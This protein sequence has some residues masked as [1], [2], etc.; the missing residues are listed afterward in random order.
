M[1]PVRFLI[2]LIQVLQIIPGYNFQQR[3]RALEIDGSGIS[4]LEMDD[5]LENMSVSTLIQEVIKRLMDT[6]EKLYQGEIN[7]LIDT[8]GRKV[9]NSG[10][11]LEQARK[12]IIS[13][14]TA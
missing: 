10:Y 7:E 13:G 9:V 11:S 4:E 2:V 12:F 14:L 3:S 8:Y 1:A 6:S 5:M